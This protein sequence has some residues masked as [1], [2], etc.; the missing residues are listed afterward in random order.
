MQ[1]TDDGP[2]DPR[3]ALPGREQ[4]PAELRVLTR[5]VAIRTGSQVLA[6]E[7]VL[8]K[9]LAPEGHVRAKRRHAELTRLIASV[10]GHHGHQSI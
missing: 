1:V 7:T 2:W 10:E 4:T 8:F 9:G 6:E 5:Q 3:Q